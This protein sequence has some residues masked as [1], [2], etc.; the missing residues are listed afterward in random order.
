MPPVGESPAPRVWAVLTAAGSGSRLGADVPKA[1]VPVRGRPLLSLAL[2]QLSQCRDIAGIVVT[3]PPGR[4]DE[5]GAAAGSVDC[6]VQFVPGG[7]TRQASVKRGLD[8]LL[9]E[10]AAQD[11]V[12]VHDAARCLAPAELINRL[13]EQIRAGHVAA[14]PGLPVSDT[15]KQVGVAADGSQIVVSTPPRSELR[16]VQTPQA[17]AWQTLWDAHVAGG[18]RANEESTAAT[19]D[20]ELLEAWGAEVSVIPGS[21]LAFKVTTPQDLDRL[22]RALQAAPEVL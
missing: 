9:P 13:A 10:V 14:I 7:P 19:D 21:E 15:I 17:F 20:A 1:L 12:L 4:E 22:S 11:I 18:A 3:C 2:E 16:T 6:P 8:A 5:F